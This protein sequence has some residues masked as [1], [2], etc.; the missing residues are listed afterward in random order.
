MAVIKKGRI[1]VIKGDTR[2]IVPNEG[3]TVTRN[4]EHLTLSDALGREKLF[5]QAGYTTEISLQGPVF[6]LRAT[7]F[8]PSSNPPYYTERWSWSKEIQ[9]RS[10]WSHP[11]VVTELNTVA[12]PSEYRKDIEQAVT[13]G[14]PLKAAPV[15]DSGL[16]FKTQLFRHLLNGEESY[17]FETLVVRRLRQ[18][19]PFNALRSKVNLP[20]VVLGANSIIYRTNTLISVFGLPPNI[21]AIMPVDP[22][23]P[24]GDYA[25]GWRIRDQNG[26]FEGHLKFNETLDWVYAPWSRLAYTLF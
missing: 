6:K 16:P 13:D 14:T 12:V 15:G 3:T 25:W 5:S 26:D 1:S 17:E 24:S 19:Y 22:P 4:S 21:Q 20:S 11:K 10:I 18:G 8:Q 9:S 2:S 23:D 7:A